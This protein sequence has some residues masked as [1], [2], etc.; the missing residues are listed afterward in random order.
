MEIIYKIVKK[1]NVKTILSI[2]YPTELQMCTQSVLKC[3]LKLPLQ[4]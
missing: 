4:S 2:I 1:N 3:D